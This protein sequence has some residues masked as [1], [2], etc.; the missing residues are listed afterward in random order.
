MKLFWK[1]QKE[2]ATKTF[3]EKTKMIPITEKE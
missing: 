2:Q 1:E 3:V